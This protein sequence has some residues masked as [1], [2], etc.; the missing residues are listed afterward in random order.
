MKLP[1]L[2]WGLFNR[3]ASLGKNLQ[4]SPG[5]NTGILTVRVEKDCSGRKL[6]KC[7]R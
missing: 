1:L 7:V 2:G 5:K 4:I 3:F 6:R